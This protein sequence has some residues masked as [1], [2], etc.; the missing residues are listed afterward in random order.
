MTSL[1]LALTSQKKKIL[2]FCV[3]LWDDLNDDMW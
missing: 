1:D 2:T 3:A